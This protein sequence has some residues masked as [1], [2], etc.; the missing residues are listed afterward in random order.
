MAHAIYLSASLFSIAKKYENYLLA[1]LLVA[2]SVRIGKSLF[3]LSFPAAVSVLSAVGLVAMSLIGPFLFLYIQSFLNSEKQFTSKQLLHLTTGLGITFFLIF[4]FSGQSLFIGYC[5]VNIQLLCYVIASFIAVQK[6]TV[7]QN[8]EVKTWLR[9]LV[10]GVGVASVFFIFQLVFS[11][12]VLYLF[13]MAALLVCMYALSLIANKYS[14]Y[15]AKPQRKM[16]VAVT[17]RQKELALKA[18]QL[19][20]KSELFKDASVTLTNVAIALKVPP[21]QLS[22]AIRSHFNCSFPELLLEYRLQVAKTLLS[23]PENQNLTIE[24]I[25][26]E[27]GF[28]TLSAFYS[29]FK[30]VCQI[31]PAQYKEKCLIKEQAS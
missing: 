11:N 15:F 25:A 21:H 6:Q 31:T 8:K 28:S 10:S 3:A 20:L 29:G 4:N 14:K 18:E 13:A 27:S 12:S 7:I 23:S 24:A 22:A 16:T 19:L 30:K 9:Y 5:A 1:F 17:P 2:L 26:Y